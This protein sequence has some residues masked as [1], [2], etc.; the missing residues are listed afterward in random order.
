MGNGTTED[1]GGA[2]FVAAVAGEAER[3]AALID[4]NVA[5][6]RGAPLSLP[7]S[8]PPAVR[9]FWTR[10][11]WNDQWA[12]R[13]RLHHPDVE[14][15][16]REL[17]QLLDQLTNESP[18]SP[19]LAPGGL[20]KRC[21]LADVDNDGIGFVLTNEDDA[22]QREDPPLTLVIFDSGK[23]STMPTS[24]L[25]WCAD[26]LIGVACSGWLKEFVAVAQIPASATEAPF[27][28][29]SPTTRAL[30]PDVWLLPADGYAGPA[31]DRTVAF[32]RPEDFATLFKRAPKHPW[33]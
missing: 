21:R 1:G 30:A 33:R 12:R 4:R 25:R 26:E 20:P 14:K 13:F 8:D 32:A 10:V 18:G 28:T 5:A 29:L 6:L 23:T 17:P 3:L 11:G 2:K 16:V 9:A 31:D 19:A 27:P 15:A 24:Y 7:E 22:Q